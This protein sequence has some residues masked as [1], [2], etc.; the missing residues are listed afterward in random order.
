M[1]EIKE[2]LGPKYGQKANEAYRTYV[3]IYFDLVDDSESHFTW[4]DNDINRLD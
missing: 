4:R 1:R 2:G 3:S